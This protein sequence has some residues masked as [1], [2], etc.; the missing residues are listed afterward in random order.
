MRS[1]RPLLCSFLMIG[2]LAGCGGGLEAGPPKEVPSGPPP[3]PPGT[4]KEMMKKTA[5]RPF[6]P[7][8]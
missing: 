3:T 4:T 2:L 6:K 8:G 5:N 7:P 1:L